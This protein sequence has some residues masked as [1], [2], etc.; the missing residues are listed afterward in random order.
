MAAKTRIYVEDDRR[1]CG[2][3]VR[4]L[5]SLL[6]LAVTA[7]ALSPVWGERKRTS[8]NVL[9]DFAALY[10]QRVAVR[11]EKSRY[12]GGLQGACLS[13]EVYCYTVQ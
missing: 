12:E 3:T 5:V 8:H 4:L 9:N 13:R 6:R 2:V 7:R 10:S 1:S 11:V